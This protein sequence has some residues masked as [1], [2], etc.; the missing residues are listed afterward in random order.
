MLTSLALS[1]I[2][3]SSVSFAEQVW[4]YGVSSKPQT[5]AEW[6]EFNKALSLGVRGAWDGPDSDK[7]TKAGLD[8]DAFPFPP[9]TCSPLTASAA[10]PTTADKVRIPDIRVMGALGDSITAAF[11]ANA[12]SIFSVFTEYR[13][14]S[15]SIGSKGNLEEEAFTLPTL[16]ETVSG[17]VTV[18]GA[19]TGRGGADSSAANL[20]QAVSGA[21]SNDLPAQAQVLIQ[22]MQEEIGA[23]RMASDWTMVTLFIGGNDLCDVCTNDAL[24]PDNYEAKVRETIEYLKANKPRLLV[25]LVPSLDVT[26]LKDAGGFVCDLLHSYECACAV[27]SSDER[28]KAQAAQVTMGERAA[29]IAKDYPGTD[30]FAVILQPFML[31]THVPRNDK[32]EVD[33]GFFAPDCFHF[34]G[35]GHSAAAIGLWNNINQKVGSKEDMWHGP[36]EAL[37]CPSDSEYIWT[38]LNSA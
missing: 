12:G 18:V 28:A 7:V 8:V 34:S 20:N 21:V 17:N 24:G 5:D 19:S 2:L 27:G 3:S 4:P 38:P 13:E 9:F 1:V 10:V 25:N 26:Q 23:E 16:F 11:G 30:D 29:A 35:E 22:R 32:G 14:V 37:I 15:W 31:N 33:M 36:A 6:T